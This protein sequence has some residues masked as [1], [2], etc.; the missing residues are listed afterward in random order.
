MIT[1]DIV[2]V[3]MAA[4]LI[5][6][7]KVASETDYLRLPPRYQNVNVPADEQ[8]Y[9]IRSTPDMGLAMFAQKDLKRGQRILVETPLLHIGPFSDEERSD[10]SIV[11]T[12]IDQALFDLASHDWLTFKNLKN[13]HEGDPTLQRLSQGPLF[14]RVLTN[15]ITAST[16][17][18]SYDTLSLVFDRMS[19]LNHSCKA[20]VSFAWN[21]VTQHGAIFALRDIAEGEELT[22]SY[23]G[24]NGEY[25]ER[26][27]RLKE[28]Y[29][30]ECKCE[31]CTADETECLASDQRRTEIKEISARFGKTTESAFFPTP[32]LKLGRRLIELIE[33]EGTRGQSVADTY[34]IAA[35]IALHFSDVARGIVFL[36]RHGESKM[37]EAGVDHPDLKN[38]PEWLRDPKIMPVYGKDER[39]KSEKG[40]IPQGKTAQEFETWLWEPPMLFASR[41]PSAAASPQDSANE[42]AVESKIALRQSKIDGLGRKDR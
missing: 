4:D 15:S 19:R 16:S 5:E 34:L 32:N 22:L 14:G 11:W 12:H 17:S 2:S 13:G 8:L 10:S 1:A 3:T 9:R 40:D 18:A 42:A 36:R 28:T 23:Y 30:F 21:K 39:W 20:N 41:S 35:S 29:N 38:W 33:I 31:L 7:L 25:E 24:T 26:R 37:H 27:G 6:R